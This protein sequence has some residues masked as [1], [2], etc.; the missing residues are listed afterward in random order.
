M[1]R[2]AAISLLVLVSLCASVSSLRE[3]LDLLQ[4]QLAVPLELLH[5]VAADQAVVGGE[6][7]AQPQGKTLTL[8]HRPV[9]ISICAPVLS[10]THTHYLSHTLSHT[11]SVSIV[12][13]Y[14]KS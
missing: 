1:L 13:I 11:L 2:P 5:S 10:L 4:S 6:A 12:I 8:F 3:T 9:P 14:P 7:A